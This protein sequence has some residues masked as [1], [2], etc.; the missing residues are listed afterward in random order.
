MF[1]F[2]TPLQSIKYKNKMPNN[3]AYKRTIDKENIKK[4]VRSK[5]LL[6]TKHKRLSIIVKTRILK[7]YTDES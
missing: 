1:H 6:D 2:N 3:L 7:K 5:Y 4:K